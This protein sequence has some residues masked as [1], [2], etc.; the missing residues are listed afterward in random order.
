MKDRI[1][2]IIQKSEL[3]KTKFAE[4]INVSAA[5][6]SQLCAGARQPS[7]R[8]ITDICREFGVNRIWLETGDGEPYT[9]L[10]VEEELGEIFGQVLAGDPRTKSR[11][12]KA[13]AR[14][15]EQA[16][17][18]IE[19]LILKMAAELRTDENKLTE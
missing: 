19:E 7:D 11:L 1:S 10:T 13:F 4:R 16:Y 15:P 9:R 5:Y 12:I 3:S 18:M 17:P 6:V 2:F 8:T 14:L